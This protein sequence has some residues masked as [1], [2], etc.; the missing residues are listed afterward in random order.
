MTQFP[1][2]DK[3]EKYYKAMVA[4]NDVVEEINEVIAPKI[5]DLIDKKEGIEKIT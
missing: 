1:E 2:R 5:N 4:I 3:H